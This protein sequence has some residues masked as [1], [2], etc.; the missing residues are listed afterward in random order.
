MP[1]HNL[2]G[3]DVGSVHFGFDLDPHVD[4]WLQSAAACVSAGDASL[5]ALNAARRRAPDQLDVLQALY[6]YHVY[7]G[8]LQQALDIVFQT[9]IK[10]SIQGGF[11]RDWKTL[12][13]ESADWHAK[14]G[15]ARSFLYGLKA[16]AFIRLRQHDCAG[17]EDILATLDRL[18]PTDQVGSGVLRDLLEG[19]RDEQRR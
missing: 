5:K 15:P 19:M 3:L 9:L 13:P 14:R 18:D 11:D 10:A 7:R 1:E 16:L 2:S 17:A 12:G 6:K 8:D 4:A